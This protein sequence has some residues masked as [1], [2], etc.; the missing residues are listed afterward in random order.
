MGPVRGGVILWLLPN[1]ASAQPE[2][3]GCAALRPGWTPGSP[4]TAWDEL[5]HQATSAP[6]LLLFLATA[7]V[8]RRCSQWGA[9]AVVSLWSVMVT[10][11][12]FRDPA[13]AQELARAGGCIGSPTLFIALVAAICVLTIVYTAPRHRRD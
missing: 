5:I 6:A 11:V 7:L 12:A 4:A 9:L 1:A 2:A 8:L 13:G 3:V 10:L